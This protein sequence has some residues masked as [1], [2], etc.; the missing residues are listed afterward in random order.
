VIRGRFDG[1]G[2]PAALQVKAAQEAVIADRSY[3]KQAPVERI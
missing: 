3:D 2:L 1:L